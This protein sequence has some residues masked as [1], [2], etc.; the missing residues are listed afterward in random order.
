MGSFAKIYIHLDDRLA[1]SNKFLQRF[2]AIIFCIITFNL[3]YAG[4]FFTHDWIPTALHKSKAQALTLQALIEPA[5]V[6]LRI[7]DADGL[8]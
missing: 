1:V 2:I 8:E 5:A 7:K 4:R 6:T 3:V